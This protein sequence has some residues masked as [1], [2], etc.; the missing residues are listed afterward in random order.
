MR[1]ELYL[2]GIKPQSIGTADRID[3]VDIRKC[4]LQVRNYKRIL[5]EYLNRTSRLFSGLN[6]YACDRLHDRSRYRCAQHYEA[7]VS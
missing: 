7:I 1:F 2:C 5:P 6:N 4:P 3:M